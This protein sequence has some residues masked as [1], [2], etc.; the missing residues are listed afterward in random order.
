MGATTGIQWSGRTW[1]PWQGCTKV[2]PGCQNCYM[3]RDKKRYGQDPATVVRSKAPTFNAPLSK[4]WATPARV[5]TCSWS[6]FFHQD[7][8]EWRY[9]AWDIIRKTP[10]LTYQILTKRPERIADNLP[11]TPGQRTTQFYDQTWPWSHVWLGTSVENQQF[12]DERIP[13]L[14]KVPATIRFLS[15]EPMLRPIDIS[16]Y[17]AVEPERWWV[18]GGGESGPNYRLC[19]IDWARSLRDQCVAA[20]VPFFWKQWSGENPKAIGRE[21]DG[22]EWSQ[23]PGGGA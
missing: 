10:H 17:L 15:V 1:N 20:G 4:K 9:E 3:Y 16:R 7:A 5:F 19:D 2:S 18:I 23:T 14:L 8:D 13:H 22:R 11:V 6:D 12:A 21:L